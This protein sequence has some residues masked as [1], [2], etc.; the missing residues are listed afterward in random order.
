MISFLDVQVSVGSGSGSYQGTAM[1]P[2]QIKSGQV[3]LR[4]LN[5]PTYRSGGQWHYRGP[6]IVEITSVNVVG[7]GLTFTFNYNF[8]ENQDYQMTGTIDFLAIADLE[9]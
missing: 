7:T 3:A 6:T 9:A 5:L 1:F 2:K 8:S 4:G